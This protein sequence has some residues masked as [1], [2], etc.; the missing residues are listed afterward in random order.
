MFRVSRVTIEENG[1]RNVCSSN[2]LYVAL[3]RAIFERC[4]EVRAKAIIADVSRML[5][6]WSDER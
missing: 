2:D 4:G 6:E 1:I 5:E 3:A